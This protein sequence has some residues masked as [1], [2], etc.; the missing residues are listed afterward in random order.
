M[1]PYELVICPLVAE[2]GKCPYD[3]H[4]GDCKHDHPHDIRESC[5]SQNVQCPDCMI[6]IKEEFI[7][8]EEMK[9]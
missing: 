7:E 1:I 6:Q 9:L 3:E 4:Q 5:I 8:E 2:E